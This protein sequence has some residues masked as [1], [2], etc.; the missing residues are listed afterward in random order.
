ML[1]EEGDPYLLSALLRFDSRAR[2][3]RWLAA[4]QQVVERHDILRMAFVGAGLSEPVQVVW[5]RA[6][7]AVIELALD[8]AEGR[9]A[10]S[11]KRASTP[12]G[13]GRI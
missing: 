5:R 1:A 12:D 2:F 6:R 7:L 10:V 4:M 9:S 8:P 3:D 11:W 13:S